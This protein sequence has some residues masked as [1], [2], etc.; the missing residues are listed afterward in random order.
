MKTIVYSAILLNVL[1]GMT[2]HAIAQV[3]PDNTLGSQVTQS[4]AVFNIDN[5]MRSGNNL[6]HSFSQ[7]SIPTNGS[8]VF[9]NVTDVQNIFSRVTGSQLSN[10]D[11]ILKSQGNANL[12]LMN[13]NGIVFGPNA[14][15][16]LGGSFLGT[17]AN[18]I[19]FEDGIVFDTLNTAPAL[20]SVKVPIGL[21]MGD[22]PG[23]IQVQGNGYQYDNTG[24]PVPVNSALRMESGRSLLL[25]GGEI[26]FDGGIATTLKGQ[27]DVGSV[28]ANSVVALIPKKFGFEMNYEGV[29]AFQDIRL[30]QLSA[31]EAKDGRVRMR[32]RQIQILNGSSIAA[33]LFQET[34]SRGIAINAAESFT[35]SGSAEGQTPQGIFPFPAYLGTSTSSQGTGTGGNISLKAPVI[36][37]SEGASIS[38]DVGQLG[39]GGDILIQANQLSVLNQGQIG[40]SSN[41]GG[42]SGDVTIQATDIQVSGVS[43][44]SGIVRPS[45]IYTVVNYGRGQA[46]TLTL[47]TERL[48]ISDGGVIASNTFDQGNAGNIII[49]ASDF[50]EI[51]NANKVSIIPTGIIADA[52]LTPGFEQQLEG[53]GGNIELTTRR[54]IVRGGT[55]ISVGNAGSG[56]AGNLTINAQSVVLNQGSLNA[57]LLAGKQGNIHIDTDVLVMRNNSQIKTNAESQANGGNISINAPIIVGLENSDIIANAQRGRGGAIQITTQSLF[58]L[59]YRDRLTPENDITASSEFGINGTVQVN[60]I[61]LNPENS[62]N[63]LPVDIVDSSRQMTDRCAAAK[64]GSFISTG[65]GGIPKSPIQTRKPDRPWHDLRPTVAT[66]SVASQPIVSS[67]PIVE[68]SA[69]QVNEA[70]A[71]SLVAA[72]SIGV[73]ISATCGMGESR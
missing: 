39:R 24:I 6:F 32:G 13:P 5:G 23:K 53:N 64:S 66:S 68:A 26:A 17:T 56:D 34:A 37:V 15:L 28:G 57:S 27:I 73:Q 7:F 72:K 48:R 18:A 2:E 69:I 21:Q 16:N 70:G 62:L 40:A 54:L 31:L 71:I 35:I 19:K 61:G 45:V 4:G 60:T 51:A 1:C 36:T 11:G 59:Q 43:T 8:A 58:G 33:M 46:G 41:G 22:N 65:R 44:I 67:Q 49:R 12:F 47:Q 9:N 14:Q 3:V 25:L 29:Q 10:I 55:T 63:T 50:V 52:T 30:N 20:L 38:A 42:I